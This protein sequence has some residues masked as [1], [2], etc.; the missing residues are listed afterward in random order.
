MK[1]GKENME[2]KKGG[3]ENFKEGVRDSDN[4]RGTKEPKSDKPTTH[5]KHHTTKP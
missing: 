3:K 4:H 2:T 1:G 5:P